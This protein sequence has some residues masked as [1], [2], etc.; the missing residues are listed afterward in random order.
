M[1][2]PWVTRAMSRD[3]EFS[4]PARS[5]DQFA[6]DEDEFAFRPTPRPV[7]THDEVFIV[8]CWYCG[9][10]IANPSDAITVGSHTY[11]VEC[12]Q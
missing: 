9:W 8:T 12:V 1:P 7:V 11:H 10:E 5:Y 3:P 6:P 4:L 2:S